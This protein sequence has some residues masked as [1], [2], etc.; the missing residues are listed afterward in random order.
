MSVRAYGRG[1]RRDLQYWAVATPLINDREHPK[2]ATVR[3]GIMY[4]VHAPALGW[5]G[6]DRGRPA[7]QGYVLPSPDPHPDLQPVEPIEPSHPLAVHHPSFP[8]QQHPDAQTAEP[9][10]GMLSTQM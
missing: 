6:W 1:E 8:A 2:R 5:P 9:R 4:K 10:P 7:V 3:E